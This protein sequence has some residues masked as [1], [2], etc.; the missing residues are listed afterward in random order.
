MVLYKAR[1]TCCRY[2]WWSRVADSEYKTLG[3]APDAD[4]YAFRVLCQY[5]SGLSDGIIA[6]IYNAV[7]D[8]MDVIN[9]HG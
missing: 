4:I 3:A 6:A 5:G 9:M 7:K 8:G 2:N 1:N